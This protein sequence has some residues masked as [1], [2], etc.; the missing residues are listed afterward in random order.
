MKFDDGKESEPGNAPQVQGALAGAATLAR[1]PRC[2]SVF[3]SLY[4]FG[5]GRQ[6]DDLKKAL[7]LE[8]AC[9]FSSCCL[10]LQ[11]GDDRD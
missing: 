8:L 11:K 2:A 10:R 6:V 5:G 9:G 1:L 3:M 4:A 7:C